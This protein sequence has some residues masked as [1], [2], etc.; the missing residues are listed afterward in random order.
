[1]E[2]HKHVKTI[3]SCPKCGN[4]EGL[5]VIPGQGVKFYYCPVCYTDKDKKKE[6]ENVSK[7]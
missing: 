2:H 5:I 4:E 7:N 3:P 6:E 1:M